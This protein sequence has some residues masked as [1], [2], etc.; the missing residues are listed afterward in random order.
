VEEAIAFTPLPDH[1]PLPLVLN[2]RVYR[3]QKQ[4]SGML[5]RVVSI[6]DKLVSQSRL[7]NQKTEPLS[8]PSRKAIHHEVWFTCLKS[9]D[10][11]SALF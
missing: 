9:P 2:L 5:E 11:F 10:C 6:K 4:R 8:L 1:S 3:H 7:T